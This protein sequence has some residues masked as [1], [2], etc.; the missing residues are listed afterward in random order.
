MRA[1]RRCVVRAVRTHR[2]PSSRH[3]VRHASCG[4]TTPLQR[5]NQL[6]LIS[7]TS[8]TSKLTRS[9]WRD[10]S[11]PS[12]LTRKR[13][14]RY[15]PWLSR[16]PGMRQMLRYT[17]RGK[18]R[19][20]QL[21]SLTEVELKTVRPCWS[22]SSKLRFRRRSA[23]IV[24]YSKLRSTGER[25]VIC[26]GSGVAAAAAT[27][28][29]RSRTASLP[30]ASSSVAQ[31]RR[32]SGVVR[33]RVY[34]RTIDCA[35]PSPAMRPAVDPQRPVAEPLDRHHVVADEEHGPAAAGRR[36]PSCRGTSSGRRAS[37]TASTS[38][39]SRISGS[40]W[41]ATAKASRR[42]MPEE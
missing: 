6:P 5:W 35:P 32:F 23:S 19:P 11:T 27:T 33:D 18:G 22:M 26:S 9:S 41:A 37:P 10:S 15:C 40:R 24:R 1:G 34:S 14:I 39:T 13:L 36:R 3:S 17:P 4:C 16:S 28:T 2:G 20:C 8:W 29:L 21:G 12:F 38:S 42:Y 25:T 7:A 31:E 30:G